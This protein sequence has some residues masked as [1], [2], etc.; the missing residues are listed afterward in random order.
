MWLFIAGLVIGWIVT[1]IAQG[2]GAGRYYYRFGDAVYKDITETASRCPHTLEVGRQIN[3]V[4]MAG[5][6]HCTA[7]FAKLDDLK[8]VHYE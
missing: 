1:N 6:A 2:A 8:A 3:G 4:H 7:V 5:C